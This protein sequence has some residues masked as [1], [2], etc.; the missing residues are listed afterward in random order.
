LCFPAAPTAAKFRL[1]TDAHSRRKVSEMKKPLPAFLQ[2]EEKKESKM[3]M[4]GKMP[5]A[6]K[7]PMKGKMPAKGK[8]C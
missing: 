2:K 3:P 8:K 4:K 7:M 6:E 1:V 5:M